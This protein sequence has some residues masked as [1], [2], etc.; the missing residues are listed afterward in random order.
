MSANFTSHYITPIL[1]RSSHTLVQLLRWVDAPSCWNFHV[2]PSVSAARRSKIC[3]N[4]R[5]RT[6]FIHSSAHIEYRAEIFS[7]KVIL[8]WVIVPSITLILF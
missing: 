8:Y 1:R 3:S 7:C 4:T 2:S 5:C 6:Y